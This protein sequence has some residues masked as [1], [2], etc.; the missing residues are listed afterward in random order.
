MCAGAG[1]QWVIS[2]EEKFKEQA[3]IGRGQ[4]IG[5]SGVL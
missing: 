2:P 5:T 4:K 1:V 3:L